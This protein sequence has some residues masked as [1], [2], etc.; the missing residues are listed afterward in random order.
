MHS[1]APRTLSVSV[2][3][4]ACLVL[5]VAFASP[6]AAAPSRL[7]QAQDWRTWWGQATI[8]KKAITLSSE[9]PASLAATHS[10]LITSRAHWGDHVFSF[11]ATTLEQLRLG[12]AP[13]PWEAA[14]VM[15]RFRDLENYYYF[16]LKPNGIE[17]GKKHGSDAQIFLAT[18][19]APRIVL[20]RADRVRIHVL[21]A[22]IRIAVNG[23]QVI[24]YTDP[25]PLPAGAVG[26]YEE[27][28]K[29]RFDSV[30]VSALSS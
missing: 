2:A 17:L 5:A 7:L 13:N 14:W 19:D 18:A 8:G 25:S 23:A 6:S 30:A 10:A 21:G 29:V 12:D 22:R 1:I 15:F 24:D 26:L 3:A 28:A 9:R 4:L 27:D 11:S 16:I 20:G